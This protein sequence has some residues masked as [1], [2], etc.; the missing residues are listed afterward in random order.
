VA[1]IIPFL[2]GAVF[3]P[4]D[5]EAMSMALDDV[6]KALQIADASARERRMIAE[7]II[8]LARDGERSPMRLRDRLLPEWREKSPQ[9]RWSGS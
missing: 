6:C 5:I 9:R 7:R 4:E 2:R 8:T 3:G 1:V